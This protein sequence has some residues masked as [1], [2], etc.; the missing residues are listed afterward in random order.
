MR[1]IVYKHRY[2]KNQNQK[3]MVILGFTF[4]Q[5]NVCGLS[6]QR[7]TAIKQY[8]QRT[9]AEFFYLNETK[10]HMVEVFKTTSRVGEK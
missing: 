10:T 8:V 4:L 7:E 6:D 9:K 2:R 1:R 5:I 3:M